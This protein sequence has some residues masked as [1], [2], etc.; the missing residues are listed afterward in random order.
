MVAKNQII[1]VAPRLV[2]NSADAVIVAAE[3]GLGI[4]RSLS[5]QVRDAVHARRLVPVLGKFAM[6][7]SPVSAIYPARR[8]ASANVATF[9]KAARNHFAS[10]P[11]VAFP[12]AALN[13]R[14]V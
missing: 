13:Q 8:V 7:A 6:P 11:L 5:Y 12:V 9:V 3:A 14:L 10:S 1:R 4:T 2:V